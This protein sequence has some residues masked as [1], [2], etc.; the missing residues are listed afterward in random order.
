MNVHTS[1]KQW[2]GWHGQSIHY[3]YDS[4]PI[5]NNSIE[6]IANLRICSKDFSCWPTLIKKNGFVVNYRG[7]VGN[8]VSIWITGANVKKQK[9]KVFS[10]KN[11]VFSRQKQSFFCR[12]MKNRFS[13]KKTAFLTTCDIYAR[14]TLFWVKEGRK[15]MNVNKFAKKWKF[16]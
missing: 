10:Q 14:I 9:N 5:R 11:N 1:N 3:T 6:K 16:F 4:T 7:S 15:R 8:K 13:L 12:V 2:S